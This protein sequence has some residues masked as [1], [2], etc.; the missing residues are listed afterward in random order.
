MY[1]IIT[2][3]AG[4]YIDIA[5]IIDCSGSIREANEEGED[6]WQ[7]VIDF[8]VD[9]VTSINVGEDE[10]HVAA[11]SFG[12]LLIV[13]RTYSTYLKCNKY[14]L[15]RYLYYSMQIYISDG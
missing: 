14:L 8:A 15:S 11:I 5:L 6:N 10:T 12:N 2:N 3:V 7:Y 13:D 4:C 9:L 1:C